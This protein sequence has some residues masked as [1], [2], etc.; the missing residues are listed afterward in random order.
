[1]QGTA[2]DPSVP[3]TALQA[4]A[5]AGLGPIIE[6][7]RHLAALDERLRQCLPENLQPHC[8]L[9]NAVPGRL[10]YLVDAPVWGTLLRRHADTLLGAAAAAGLQADALTV[11]ITPPS[12]PEV[13][14]KAIQPLSEATR[15]ALRLTAESVAD[16][17]LR[18]QL[19]RLAS[20]A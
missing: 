13:G 17:A 20:L 2:R 9:G 12:A 6:R 8:R 3:R 10:V 15:D 5:E 7:A 16:P 11:K 19:L 4:V 1:M 18:A 14:T